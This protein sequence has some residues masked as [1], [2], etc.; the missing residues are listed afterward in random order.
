[1]S[2]RDSAMGKSGRRNSQCKGSEAEQVRHT[3]GTERRR[4]FRERMV[5]DKAE[6]T[7]KVGQYS[8]RRPK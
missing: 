3:P 1:M 8:Q 7:R 6:E 5:T 2:D 4:G